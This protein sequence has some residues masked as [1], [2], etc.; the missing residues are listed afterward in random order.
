MPTIGLGITGGIAAYK[1]PELAR[2]LRK[3]GVSVRVFFS[4]NA[5]Q[6]VT[7][8]AMA[9]TA[10]SSVVE[11]ISGAEGY[12]THIESLRQMDLMVVSP[13]TAHFIAKAA[14]GLC[15]DPV[16]LAF[17]TYKGPK[18]IVPA[19]HDSMYL[20]PA[21]EENI[22][23]LTARG[24]HVLGPANGALA[25][26]DAGIGRMVEPALIELKIKLMLANAADLSGRKILVTVGGTREPIDDVRFVTNQ[27][28]GKLGS[29]IAHAA[30]LSGAHTTV[31]TTVPIEPNPHFSNVISVASAEEM[32]AALESLWPTTDVLFMPAAVSDFT[33]EKIQGKRRRGSFGSLAVTPTEDILKLL[34]AS[35]RTDQ[36]LVGFCVETEKELETSA[37]R[38]LTDKNLDYIVA[39]TPDQ[40]GADLRSFMIFDRRTTDIRTFSDLSLPESASEIIR[41]AQK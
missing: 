39:N 7:P 26:G 18:L 8:T 12:I 24:V 32:K 28:S 4:E 27:S 15:D 41:L 16:S 29:A 19:M 25:S 1:M 13:A 38:K 3:S 31:V 14:C 36:L 34:G 21:V 10:E 30:A 11:T 22:R 2:R 5:N 37:R 9:V 35:K 40:F 6:F 23:T 17:L 20:N 33:V